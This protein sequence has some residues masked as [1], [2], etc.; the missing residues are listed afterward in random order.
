[1][2]RNEVTRIAVPFAIAL[3]LLVSLLNQ[4]APPPVE[5]PAGAPPVPPAEQTRLAFDQALA[6]GAPGYDRGAAS[7]PVNLR[8]LGED[9]APGAQ[10]QWNGQDRP[11]Q[12]VSENE[13]WVTLN[14]FDVAFGG[15]GA[16]TV[17]NPTPGGGSSNP[18]A[19]TIFAYATYLPM[20]VR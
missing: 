2:T 19:F 1:M 14:G 16:V 17:V 18:A 11:T 12:M 4:T 20:T 3:V 8:V 13:L 5:L 6:P 10:A 7:A 9:F 15:S